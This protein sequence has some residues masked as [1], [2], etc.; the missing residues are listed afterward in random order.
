MLLRQGP[1]SGLGAERPPPEGI[2]TPVG[3]RLFGEKE[4]SN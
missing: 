2:R 4:K 1:K 3:L